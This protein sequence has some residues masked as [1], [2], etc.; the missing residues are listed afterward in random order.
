MKAAICVQ[1]SRIETYSDSLAA[2][3]SAFPDVQEVVFLFMMDQ[4]GE[5]LLRGVEAD[6]H[7]ANQLE[8]YVHASRRF[9]STRRI[10]VLS[11]S[12]LKDFR[13][14][15]VTGVS[16]EIMAEVLPIALTSGQSVC[17]LSWQDQI[18][19]DRKYV[20]EDDHTY[21]DAMKSPVV[22]GIYRAQKAVWLM[23]YI[24]SAIII[25]FAALYAAQFFGLDIISDKMVNLLGILVALGG[26][27]LS[28]TAL[29]LVPPQGQSGE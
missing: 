7:H 20:G 6:L 4:D 26:L 22:Q 12:A 21:K 17:F 25:S 5:A 2:M 19:H 28:Y 11:R 29:R 13:V 18:S 14:I 24:L 3:V 23:F 9:R 1:G 15:D 10:Q 27:F 16:K 8:A